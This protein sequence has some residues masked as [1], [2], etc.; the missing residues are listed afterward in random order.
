MLGSA[1]L[2]TL[3][4]KPLLRSAAAVDGLFHRGAVICEADADAR[5]Y[6]SI[7]AALE[8]EGRLAGAS[9]VY[10]AA[11][12]G[13]GSLAT[14][15]GS[16]TR[17]GLPTA[18]VADLDLLR[19]DAELDAVLKSLGSD[20]A[21]FRGRYN[22]VIS[23]LNAIP[24]VQSIGEFVK[25]ARKVLIKVAESKK[26]SSEMRKELFRLLENAADW[27]EVKR[28]GISK[29]RGG[30]LTTG[31]DLLEE[32]R[33]LGLFLVPVG[34]LEGWWPAGPAGATRGGLDSAGD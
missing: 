6:T 1:E 31:Q 29:H 12:G 24:P 27:S 33:S 28:L 17:L 21:R 19:N 18:V 15:A 14:L 34:E 5:F 10:F 11:G 2:N 32:W 16:Y 26:L 7:A 25:G 20:L 4:S 13:K 22:S 3:W 23:S 30:S 8:S 9:D